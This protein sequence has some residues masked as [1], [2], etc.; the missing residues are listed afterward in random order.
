MTHWKTLLATSGLFLLAWLPSA[1]S[2]R[3]VPKRAIREGRV[4]QVDW[5]GLQSAASHGQFRQRVL[6]QEE[7]GR[8]KGD[9]IRIAEGAIEIETSERTEFVKRNELRW[10]RL[11]PARGNNWKWR[12]PAAIGAVPIGIGAYILSF[13]GGF[14]EG[15]EW[16]ALSFAI[17]PAV[18]VPSVVYWLALKADRRSGAL[19]LVVEGER[20]E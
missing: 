7:T 5:A 4:L 13:L 3:A 18:V 6:V 1:A 9:L 20:K 14:P 15:G 11:I 16:N 19:Y 17:F 10:I 2:D 12:T 8:I